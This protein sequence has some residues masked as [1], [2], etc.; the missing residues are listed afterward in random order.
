MKLICVY[1]FSHSAQCIFGR[2]E[3]AL[4]ALK[5]LLILSEH[6]DLLCIEG[7]NLIDYIFVFL[8]QGQLLIDFFHV[9]ELGPFLHH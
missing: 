7:A 4:I 2:H 1:C 3:E 8:E 9:V 6:L 5:P